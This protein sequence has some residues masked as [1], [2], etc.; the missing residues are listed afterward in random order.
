MEGKFSLKEFITG[1]GKTS[2]FKSWGYGW[3]LIVTILVILFVAVTIYRAF[4]VKNQTQTQSMVVYPF[5]FSNITYAPQQQQKQEIKKRP[6]WLPILFI[7]GYG[8][9]ESGI[10]NSRTGIGGKI[11][12]RLEF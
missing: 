2:W 9:S 5:S 6:W 7:E 12:G 8:F 11:G 1:G 3:R 10:G 4:F